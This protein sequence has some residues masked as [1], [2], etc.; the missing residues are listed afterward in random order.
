MRAICVLALLGATATAAPTKPPATPTVRANESP[1]RKPHP[2]RATPRGKPHAK[3]RFEAPADAATTP[4]VT[5]GQLSATD[6]EAELGNRHIGY[7]TEPARG[8][9]DPVRLTGT[10]HGVEFRT[11]ETDTQRADSPYEI[12][13]CRL[14]LALDDFAQI[15]AR[16]DIVQVRHYSMYRPPP[17][18]WAADR[19]GGQHNGALALDAGRFTKQDGTVLDVAKDF[20]GKIGDATCGDGAG[21]HPA[22][23]AATELRSIL[24]EA[25]AQHLFNVVLTPNFN[26]PHH[27][28]FHL[29]VM[30]SVKWFLVH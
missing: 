19:I 17:K 5:Y 25:V 14:V 2:A 22:S 9:F 18:S 30:A 15:L 8:V 6:C 24:C 23:A 16:H 1:A 10:L 13:D 27:N 21:P 3:S 20:H 7:A 11:D 28:H 26:R 29:E 4:A 12:A